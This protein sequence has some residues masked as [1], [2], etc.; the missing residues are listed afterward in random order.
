MRGLESGDLL[1]ESRISRRDEELAALTSSAGRDRAALEAEKERVAELEAE[2]VKQAKEREEE[3]LLRERHGFYVEAEQLHAVEA[4]LLETQAKHEGALE[5]HAA[6]QASLD[7][8]TTAR[9]AAEDELHV[10]R[11]KL[12]VAHSDLEEAVLEAG[13]C[14][15][16]KELEAL[17]ASFTAEIETLK[18]LHL[19]CIPSVRYASPS[20]RRPREAQKHNIC[21]C[22]HIERTTEP[23]TPHASSAHSPQ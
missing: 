1:V 15:H 5:A 8:M 4:T 23:A 7:E 6:T 17:R 16:A 11:E 19:H 18:A 22:H 9:H 12:A 10:T 13:R 3:R 2:A 20:P 21:H 14:A